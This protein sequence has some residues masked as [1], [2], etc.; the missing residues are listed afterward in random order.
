MAS[1]LEPERG[2]IY[3]LV[4]YLDR[5]L[6][7]P[8]IS[9]YACVGRHDGAW[10]FQE[11]VSFKKEGLLEISAALGH[12]ECLCIT[13]ADVSGIL[14][15]DGLVAELSENKAMQDQGRSLAERT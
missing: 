12:P 2:Q 9:T 7:I 11:A 4:A 8:H 1:D 13:D 14:N 5:A 10:Y 3:F 15:W 6:R